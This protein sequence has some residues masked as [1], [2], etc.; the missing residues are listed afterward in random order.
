MNKT[1]EYLA[2]N[3][4]I[5]SVY[6]TADF[7]VKGCTNEI[8]ISLQNAGIDMIEVGIPFSDPLADGLVIQNSSKKSL[9]NGFTLDNLVKDLKKIQ[10]QI[11]IPIVIM[12]YFNPILSF[13]LDDFLAACQSLAI[14]TVII[15]DLPPDL[16]MKT[17]V[18]LFQKNNVSPVF[19][20]TPQTKKPRIELIDS[21]SN[22]FIYA[23]AENTITGGSKGFSDQ[24]LRYFE[25]INESS[26]H[27]PAMIGFGISDHKGFVE[28]CK[29]AQGVI[30]GSAFIRLLEKTNNINE[31]IQHFTQTIK[32]GAL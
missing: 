5:L 27:V 7:P 21:L 11:N 29:Y 12:G 23:V 14:D 1:G 6:F 17:Y 8:I 4:N 10:H 32:H 28:A 15:P 26:F 22:A 3:K 30:I 2:K 16:Y 20:I 19:L 25:K 13:G 24:Q 31:T 9:E 18:S